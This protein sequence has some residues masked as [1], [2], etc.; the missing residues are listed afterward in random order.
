MT[1]NLL[2]STSDFGYPQNFLQISRV[3]ITC[4]HCLFKNVFCFVLLKCSEDLS[5][6]YAAEHKLPK[7]RINFKTGFPF[8]KSFILRGDVTG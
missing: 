2:F 8:F 1:L 5:C 7:M 3:G 4:L 6:V